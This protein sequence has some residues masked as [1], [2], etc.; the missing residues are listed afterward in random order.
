MI[1][2]LKIAVITDDQETVSPHFGM[3]RYYMV[4]EIKDG[5]IINKE[6]KEKPFHNRE[7]M[8]H[9]HRGADEA[10]VHANMLSGVSDCEALISRG[11]G[12][13]MYFSIL[14]MGIKPYVTSTALVDDAIKE[15]IQGTL[16]NH[17]ERLH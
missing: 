14:Q 5:V 15:Y 6:A 8:N 12:R 3:A 1:K 16:D 11:M 2:V 9:T 13:G 4:Y 7:G 17:V 10:S